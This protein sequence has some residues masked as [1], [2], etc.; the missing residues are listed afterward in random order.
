MKYPKEI[1]DVVRNQTL[2]IV[3]GLSKATAEDK[4]EPLKFYHKSFHDHQ[5]GEKAGNRQSVSL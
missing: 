2:Y 4:N 1:F 5:S 3:N